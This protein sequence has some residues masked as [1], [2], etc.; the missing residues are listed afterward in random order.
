MPYIVLAVIVFLWALLLS[1][2]KFPKLGDESATGATADHGH[3]K[4]LLRYP[5][6]I[7]AVLA[8]FFY[9]GAQVGTWSY[10]IQYVQDYT[11]Q[12]EKVAGYFLTGTLAAFAVGRFAATYLMK[13]IAPNVLMGFYSLINV[14]L[15]AI[16]VLIPGWIGLWAI[17]ATSFFMSLM[18]PTIFGLGLR[19]LGPNTK[20]GGSLLVMAIIGGAVFTPAMGLVAEASGSMARAMIVPLLCYLFIAYF[21]YFGSKPR[22]N[23]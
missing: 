20:L 3:Y 19:D 5:H 4:D 18:F 6:F 9:V 21:S 15:V 12:S 2:T 23:A 11:S 8:Q 22:R 10:F 16:G 7:K 17:F 13:Y 1:K 14:A